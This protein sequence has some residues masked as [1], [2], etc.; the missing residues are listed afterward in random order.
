MTEYVPLREPGDTRDRFPSA[1]EALHLEV[2]YARQDLFHARLF[3]TYTNRNESWDNNFGAERRTQA[4]EQIIEATTVFNAAREGVEH[5]H[6]LRQRAAA[7]R[8]GSQNTEGSDSNRR[9]G[10]KRDE[11]RHSRSSQNSD[12][13]NPSR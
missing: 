4:S 2:D 8:M 10:G 13:G 9:N 11:R 12:R 1:R 3:Q 5:N 7:A 6:N